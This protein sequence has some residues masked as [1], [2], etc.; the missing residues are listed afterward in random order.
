MATKKTNLKVAEPKQPPFNE[1]EINFLSQR[2]V[3]RAFSPYV[4]NDHVM[5]HVESLGDKEADAL[6]TAIDSS[7][8]KLRERYQKGERGDLEADLARIEQAFTF[9]LG[10]ETGRRVRR[11]E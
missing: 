11:A 9:S 10:L 5:T 8:P 4:L 1:L 2:L 3:D 7:Y 6:R